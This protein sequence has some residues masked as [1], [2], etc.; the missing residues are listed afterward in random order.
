M[1]LIYVI[2]VIG[3]LF[4]LVLTKLDKSIFQKAL[5]LF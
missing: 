4:Y 3:Q 1:S 5:N 2:T